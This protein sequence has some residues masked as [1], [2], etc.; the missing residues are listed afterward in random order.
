MFCT[1]CGTEIPENTAFC[2]TCATPANVQ[3]QDQPAW[4]Q[5]NVDSLRQPV[6]VT[7]WLV[8]AIISTLC[9]CLPLG[10]VSIVFAAQANSK[11]EQGNYEEAQKAADKAKLFFILAIALGLVGDILYFL[12]QVLAAFAEASLD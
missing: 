12:T 5:Q 8:P 10:V 2:P 3:S 4:A 11:A 6:K 9:C 1:K 7:N